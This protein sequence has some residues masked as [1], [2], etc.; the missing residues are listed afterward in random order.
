MEVVMFFLSAWGFWWW[1]TFVLWVVLETA[2]IDKEDGIWATIFFVA[3]L[4][5]LQFAFK[6]GIFQYIIH[7]PLQVFALIG[8]YL[9]A[10]VIWSVTKWWLLLAKERDHLKS[11]KA[12]YMESYNYDPEE[13]WKKHVKDTLDYYKVSNH[14]A[15]ISLWITYWPFSLIWSLLN[16]FV[17]RIIKEIV[18]KLQWLYDSIGKK[19]FQ[20]V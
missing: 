19:M 5:A 8:F 18:H 20:G 11:K 16:D 4:F 10:G 12:K 9:G 1:L 6:V 13:Y 3:Y 15:K 2:C 17:H 7:N 14:K